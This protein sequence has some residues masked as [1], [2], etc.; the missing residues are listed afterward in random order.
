M[1]LVYY[2]IFHLFQDGGT[3]GEF[4]LES[5]EGLASCPEEAM[6]SLQNSIGRG[7]ECQGRQSSVT[8]RN[9]WPNKCAA[10]NNRSTAIL[11]D[12][13]PLL[14]SFLDL[15]KTPW[16]AGVFV[17]SGAVSSACHIPAFSTCHLAA[18][19]SCFQ[20]GYQYLVNSKWCAWRALKKAVLPS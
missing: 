1:F 2:P 8:S 19:G 10:H 12:E 13:H 20:L 15:N 4:I 7:A 16:L 11:Q 5:R 3:F 17:T 6:A 14:G 9:S 18:G